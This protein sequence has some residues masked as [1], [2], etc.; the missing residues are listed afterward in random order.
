MAELETTIT[1]T[2]S[3]A[4]DEIQKKTINDDVNCIIKLIK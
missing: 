1:K 3:S 2:V 4:R